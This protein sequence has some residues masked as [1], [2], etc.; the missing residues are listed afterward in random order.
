VFHFIPHS[1][2]FG[3]RLPVSKFPYIYKRI[4]CPDTGTLKIPVFREMGSL[5]HFT[6]WMANMLQLKDGISII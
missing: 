4:S 3:L 5:P 1:F 2:F 6:V